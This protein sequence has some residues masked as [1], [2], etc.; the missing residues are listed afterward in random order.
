[1]QQETASERG[2]LS[3]YQKVY[4]RKLA[5]LFQRLADSGQKAI[6]IKGWASQ[7][8]YADK[9]ERKPGDLDLIVDPNE[10]NEF[11]RDTSGLTDLG[12][13]LHFGP[14]HLD[15]MSFE[16][17]LDRS[18]TVDL[19]EVPVRVLCQ[20]DHLRILC[21]HWLTDGGERKERLW[22]IYWAVEN[23]SPDFDWQKCLNVVSEKRQKWIIY[24][25]G[26]ANKHLDLSLEDLPFKE[27]A[28]DLPSWLSEAVE[29]RWRKG[30][31]HVPLQHVVW[32]P[33]QL[34][35]Q[36]LKRFPPNPVMALVGFEGDFDA[37]YRFHY[38][39]G[40][41]FKQALPSFRRVYRAVRQ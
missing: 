41:I 12:L 3:L 30:I 11:W 35:Q 8:L 25:I 36:L 32:Y 28:L 9:L 2:V 1:M 21:V 10:K 6:V 39:I 40:F 34:L 20:E 18:V 23:R 5:D 7:R 27:E 33:K 15:S 31:P 37:R 4:E 19:E 16:D 26:L 14:R 24:T 29:S 17:L 38:Q 22:D 13:D